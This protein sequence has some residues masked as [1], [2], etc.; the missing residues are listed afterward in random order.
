MLTVMPLWYDITM[1]QNTIL[2]VD[3]DELMRS[4]LVEIIT[5]FNLR[6]LTAQ[7][8]K[9][10]LQLAQQYLPDLILLDVMMP[11]MD[12]FEVCRRL[13]D[14]PMLAQIPIVMI[15]GLHDREAKIRGFESGADEFITKPFDPGE[16][17]ARINTVLRLNRYRRLL[18]EQARVNAERARFEWVVE[19]SDNAYVIV[20]RNDRI[21]YANQRARTYL[22]LDAHDQPVQTL[23][24]LV[25]QRYRL[26]PPESWERWPAAIAEPRYLVHPETLHSAEQWLQVE[27]TIIQATDDQVVVT[28]RDVTQQ[29][30][31]QRD[32]WTFHTAISHKLRTPLTSIINGLTILHDNIEHMDRAMARNIAA[33]ALSSAH[34]LQHAIGDILLYASSPGDIQQIDPCTVFDLPMIVAAINQDL[35]MPTISLKIDPALDARRLLI[36][37]RSLEIVLRELCENA[38]KFHPQQHPVV[39]LQVD[40]DLAQQQVRLVLCDDGVHLPPEQLQKIWQP[41]YQA[42]RNFTGQVEG[43]GLGLAQ[44]ARIILAVGGSYQMRNRSDRLGICV[45][46][47]IPFAHDEDFKATSNRKG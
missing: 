42:E 7:R 47:R 18:Q 3:D 31:A 39:T 25:A 2:I 33:I 46:L 35:A 44:V 30:T 12:G 6:L 17:Q 16:L 28:L 27:A 9:Q 21:R 10:A 22:G 29:I 20:D 4:L 41:Y 13:R 40:A 5:P 37:R 38:R 43:M 45:E 36:S 26:V 19:T 23:R 1:E 15:T 32:M 34:R 14:D 11:D 24:E 8:G